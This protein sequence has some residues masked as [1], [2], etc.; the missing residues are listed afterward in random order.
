MAPRIGRR[1][2]RARGGRLRRASGAAL[3]GGR[4]RGGLAWAA[5]RRGFRPA[6]SW[7]AAFFGAAFLVAAF[8]AAAF[9]GDLLGRLLR[10]LR[11]AFLAAFF[12]AAAFLAWRPSWR[13]FFGRASA[14]FAAFFVPPPCRRFAGRRL[15]VFFARL[16]PSARLVRHEI[17]WVA[18]P[19]RPEPVRYVDRDARRVALARLDTAV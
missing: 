6:V 5:G 4:L 2:G 18:C 3:A 16:R 13:A 14:F 9:A 1:L 12:L 8:L 7:P 10:G 15:A 11:A 17:P 19:A